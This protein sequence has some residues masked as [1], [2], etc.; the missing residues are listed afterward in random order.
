MRLALLG[1]VTAGLMGCDMA[2]DLIGSGGQDPVR[3][4]ALLGGDV[5]VQAPDGYCIDQRSS[6]ARTGFAVM[7]GCALL[8]DETVMP[9]RDGL[10][11]V[12]FGDPGTAS[13]AGAEQAYRDLLTSASGAQLLSSMGDASSIS[14]DAL[15]S[16]SNLVSVHFSDSGEPPFDGLEQLEWRAFFD[17]SDRL[18]T[19]TVRGFERAPL[20]ED[21]GLA[22]LEQAV[23]TLQSANPPSADRPADQR[24]TDVATTGDDSES[25]PADA[26]VDGQDTGFGFLGQA[27]QSLLGTNQASADDVNT[28][29]A[30]PNATDAA[31]S[32][33]ADS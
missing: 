22:L 24:E 19:V 31:E 25:T 30:D 11:T 16:Q 18:C 1:L 15:V 2:T 8:S 28:G 27:V 5:A 10:I 6:K 29:P 23:R 17:L 21:A 33:E 7:A 32:E 13:V 4:M 26:D 20:S 12:Q 9:Y 14:V 3:S